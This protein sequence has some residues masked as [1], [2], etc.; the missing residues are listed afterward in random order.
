[1]IK[2]YYAIALF[3]ATIASLTAQTAPEILLVPVTS[4][5]PTLRL[6]FGYENDS[7]QIYGTNLTALPI[8][9]K[10]AKFANPKAKLNFVNSTNMATSAIE[11]NYALQRDTSLGFRTKVTGQSYYTVLKTSFLSGKGNS[12]I[13]VN[14]NI[15]L[16]GFPASATWPNNFTANISGAGVF[17]VRYLPAYSGNNLLLLDSSNCESNTTKFYKIRTSQ[18]YGLDKITYKPYNARRRETVKKSFDIFFESNGTQTKA[19]EI[20]AITDYLEQNKFEILNATMEGGSSV[21]GDQDRNKKLQLDRAKVI[22]TALSK[23]NK[24]AVKKDT[25]MLSDNWPRFR[26]QIKASPYAWLDTLSNEK[27]LN[28]INSN[29]KLRK[30]IE[31]I[32]KTQRKASLN[33]TMAKI[34]NADDQFVTLQKSLSAWLKVLNTPTKQV[35]KELEPQIMGAIAYVFD[36]HLNGELNNEEIDSLLAGGYEA[37]KYIFLGLHIIKQFTDGKFGPEKKDTWG[38]R[39]SSLELERWFSRAQD[40]MSGLA[41]TGSK[42]DQTKFLKLQIDFQTFSYRMINL[43]VL[44]VNYLCHVHYPEKPEYQNINLN[45]NAFMYEMGNEKG[46]TSRCM[47]NRMELTGIDLT[48]IDVTNKDTSAVSITTEIK[49]TTFKPRSFTKPNYDAS[50]KSTYYQMLKQGFVKGNKSIAGSVDGVQSLDAIALYHLL[51]L[52]IAM[53]KPDENLFYDKDIRLEEMDRLISQ[54]KRSSSLCT[55]QANRL[56]LDYHAKALRY[57][58]LFFEPGSAKHKDIADASLK[59]VNEYYK[60]HITDFKNDDALKT[61]LYLNRFNWFPGNNEGAWYGFD[62]LNA[63]AR[64]RSLTPAE[65]KLFSNYV[66]LYDSEFKNPLPSGFSKETLSRGVERY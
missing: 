52:T 28:Q 24:S 48:K 30:G 64:K 13:F 19:S 65:A 38:E 53:W 43:G 3:L 26:E 16:G 49:R 5:Y 58:E 31:P 40:A 46:I 55:A 34:L 12:P 56:Y 22:S 50:E 21:E 33:L 27:I 11:N 45:Q 44:D 18:G 42:A 20:K 47:H 4:K 6:Q 51:D 39:W 66:L 10:K 32:L 60:K 62:L 25:I 9:L 35:N 7:V 57:L 36:Q 63:I 15:R 61:A 8:A 2:L 54:L 1:M 14:Q 29:D 41:E 23:Y 17:T 37:N 59:Y